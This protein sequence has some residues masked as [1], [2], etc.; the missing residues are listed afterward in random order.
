MGQVTLLTGPG[1]HAHLLAELLRGAG[2]LDKV[3]DYF[4][5]WVVYSGTGEVTDKAPWYRLATRGLWAAWRR[6][7]IVG[8]GRGAQAWHSAL[9]D[10]LVKTRV[11]LAPIL[12]AW[13]GTSLC[14]MRKAH[15]EGH[16]VLLEAPA[17]HPRTWNRIAKPLY[18][19]FLPKAKVISAILPENY[20]ARLEA[21]ITEADQV[22]V[23]S[24]FAKKTFIEA[25]VPE[26]KLR[27]LPLGVNTDLFYPEASEASNRFVV[28]YVGRIDLLKGVQYLLE[29]FQ[30]LRLPNAE[31]WLVGHTA[32]EM[33]P[34]LERYTGEK[35]RY[36]GARSQSELRWYYNQ[37]SVVVFPTLLD[38]FGMVILEAMACAKPVIATTHS[39]APD[40]FMGAEGILIPP[41]S[42]EAL[43]ETLEK[44][45]KAPDQLREM[46]KAAYTQVRRCYSL[47][48]YAKRVKDYLEEFLPL[49]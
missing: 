4:P 32:S 46:G 30:R 47:Q 15:R 19:Q 8:K 1:Q 22:H 7:P 43:A 3:V 37:A 36:F 41:A 26:K 17:C 16:L 21:E 35:N 9:Y 40:V 45:Y 48:A 27:I 49:S 14:T 23:L 11:P 31:L 29:A 6:V 25:G 12:W 20:V 44:A 28:L 13:W 39:G 5:D 42:V 33:K 38:S 18:S 24:S 10:W 2:Y 34:L